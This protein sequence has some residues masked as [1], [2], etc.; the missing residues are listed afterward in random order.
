MDNVS[1]GMKSLCED[2]IT[3]HADRKSSIKQL[4][5]Q[6]EVIRE[7]ARRFLADSKKFHEEMSEGL[8][9]RLQEGKDELIKNVNTIR[10]DFRKKEEEIRVD[11]SEASKIWNEMNEALRSKKS[12]SPFSKGGLT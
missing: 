11:L 6:A 8:K 2:I 12:K 3:S 1:N 5:E 10:E 9:N 7:N 4:K